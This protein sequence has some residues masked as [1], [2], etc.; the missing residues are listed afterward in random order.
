ML[1][2]YYKEVSTLANDH[3]KLQLALAFEMKTSF[4]SFVLFTAVLC[5]STN[6]ILGCCEIV[7]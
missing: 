5:F 4:I 7:V 6:G 1:C 2:V 3:C